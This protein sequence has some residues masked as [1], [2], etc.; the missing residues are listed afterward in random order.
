MKYEF[1]AG[2]EQEYSVKRMCKVLGVKRSGYYAWK[3]RPVSPREQSNAELLAKVS[4]AFER[5]RKLY[6]SQRI[7]HYLKRKGCVVS[8][9]RIAWLIRGANLIPPRGT[10]WHPRTT[11]QRKGARIAPNRLN[12]DFHADQP[13]Q[14]WVSDITYIGTAGGWLCLASI[15]DLYSPQIVG[16][17]ME[18]HM[19]ARL[20]EK[21]WEMAVTNRRPPAQLLIH[22]D[23]GNQVHQ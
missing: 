20:M 1:V 14:K 4:E 9:Q 22:S 10:K 2:H 19:D 12:Q 3:R 8:P 21:A 6:G 18:D 11:R 7:R 17:A 23:R 15:L 5:N 16:W 13:N